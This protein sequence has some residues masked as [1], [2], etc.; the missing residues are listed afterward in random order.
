MKEMLKCLLVISTLI[1][2]WGMPALALAEECA[3]PD[4]RISIPDGV[5]ASN[6][7]MKT[8]RDEVVA[9]NEQGQRYLECV[10]RVESAMQGASEQRKALVM[11]YNRVAKRMKQLSLNFNEQLALYQKQQETR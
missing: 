6:Q 5:T 10:G 7:A 4:D 11:D 1:S 3:E 2:A 9:Y 8:A